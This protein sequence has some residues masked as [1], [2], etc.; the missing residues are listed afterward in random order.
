MW[1]HMW[2]PMMG[3]T[4]WDAGAVWWMMLPRLLVGGSLLVLGVCAGNQ[5]SRDSAQRQDSPLSILQERFARGEIN[6]EQFEETKRILA[7]R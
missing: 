4:G 1:V 6:Q 3:F 7:G 5:F 2:V